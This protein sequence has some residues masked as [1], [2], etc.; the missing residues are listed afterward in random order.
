MISFADCSK[1]PG[2]LTCVSSEELPVELGVD[3]TSRQNQ[4]VPLFSTIKIFEK[5]SY[6]T[7]VLVHINVVDGSDV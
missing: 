5:G 1:L 6:F 3:M 4:V 2:P 7:L